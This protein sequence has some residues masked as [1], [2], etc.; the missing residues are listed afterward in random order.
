MMAE[1]ALGMALATNAAAG[2]RTVDGDRILVSDLAP[3]WPALST[4]PPAMEIGFAPSPGARRLFSV[5]ELRRLA[6]RHGVESTP[7]GPL[8]FERRVAPLAPEEIL[9]ALR[10]ALGESQAR[11]ELVDYLRAPVPVGKLEFPRNGLARVAGRGVAMWRGR[12]VYGTGRSYPFWA[13]VR[14]SVERRRVVALRALPAGRPIEASAVE[15]RMVESFP[16]DDAAAQTVE[17]VEGKLPRRTIAAGQPV[18]ACQLAAPLE[19]AAGA[20]V[21]VAGRSGGARLGFRAKAESPGR[22]GETIVARNPATGKRFRALVEGKGKV[23]VEEPPGEEHNAQQDP[24]ERGRA[25][26]GGV[27]GGQEE[28][29]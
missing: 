7:A 1:L 21:E 5:A 6:A 26:A 24:G 27:G 13:R 14:V 28:D 15:A 3:A 11:M 17:Q 16:F 10:E 9:R 22:A 29:R 23:S 20:E 18:E 25:G 4:L 8:C 2:C 19:V 12:I